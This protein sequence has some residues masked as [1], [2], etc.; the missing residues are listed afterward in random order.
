MCTAGGFNST[1]FICRRRNVLMSILD[2]HRKEGVKDTDLIKEELLTEKTL[3]VNWNVKNDAL[4][5]KVSLKEKPRN[6]GGILFMLSY[7]Y[8][9]LGLASPFILKGRLILQ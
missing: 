5:F 2:I 1:K 6:R 4:C 7:F 9:P 3:G 8:D